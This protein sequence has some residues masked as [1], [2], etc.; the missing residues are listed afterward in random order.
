MSPKTILHNQP[1]EQAAVK[2]A[3]GFRLWMVSRLLAMV[4]PYASSAE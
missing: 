4:I 1:I 2:S 3:N